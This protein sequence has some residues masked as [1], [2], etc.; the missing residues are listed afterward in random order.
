MGSKRTPMAARPACHSWIDDL[1]ECCGL[2]AL[3]AIRYGGN[4]VGPPVGIPARSWLRQ[5]I[6]EWVVILTLLP[7]S[8]SVLY[9]FG[10]SLK[11]SRWRW[12]P[13]G[14]AVATALWVAFAFSLRFYNAHSGSAQ[15]IYGGLNAVATLLLWL[16]GTGA[17]IFIGDEANS[18]IGKAAAKAADR[19]RR[20]GDPSNTPDPARADRIFE[21]NGAGKE[22]PRSR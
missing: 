17:A 16:Y 21:E 19:R 3:A 12:S 1:L 14:G 22:V 8:F 20:S 5:R 7:L 6:T 2:M 11:D 13:P 10:P 15:R 9:R 4:V 18:E